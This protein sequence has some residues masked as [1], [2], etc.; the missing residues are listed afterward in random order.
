[1]LLDENDVGNEV[2]CAVGCVDGAGGKGQCGL[3]HQP[4]PEVVAAA[5]AFGHE[6]NVQGGEDALRALA[7]PSCGSEQVTLPR[8][9]IF[10]GSSDNACPNSLPKTF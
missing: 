3:L 5:D 8:H 2:G 9:V 4:S 7:V 10:A 6:I 1:M